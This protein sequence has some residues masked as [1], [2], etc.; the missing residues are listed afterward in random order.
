MHSFFYY[1]NKFHALI[2][3]DSQSLKNMGSAPFIFPDI[4]FSIKDASSSS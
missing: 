4:H 3:S 2:L 1:R